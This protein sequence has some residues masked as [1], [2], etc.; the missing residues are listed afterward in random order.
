VIQHQRNLKPIVQKYGGSSLST[1]DKVRRVAQKIVDSAKGGRP[2]VVVVSAMGN[3]TSELI[4][5]AR[6]VSPSPPRRE[7]DVL[8]SSGERMSTAL[9]AMA[10]QEAGSDAISLTGP[11]S[12]ILTDN[13]HANANIVDVQPERVAQE[14]AT[15]NIVIVAGFQ[16]LSPS[17]E[18]TTIGRGGSD[19]TAVALAGALDAE[20]CDIY[21]DVPGV[22][23]ADPRIVS[24]PVHLRQIDS[25]LMREYSLHGARVLHPA[26][27]E[28]AR[29]SGV[30]IHAGS[31]FGED[32][33]TRIRCEASLA[34]TKHASE[35]PSIVGVTSRKS[36]VSL[37]S[38]MKSAALFERALD[39]L[40]GEEVLLRQRSGDS[41]DLL[42]DIEDV[43]DRERVCAR[44][45]ERLRGEATVTEELASVSIVTQPSITPELVARV[46][47]SL[48]DAGIMTSSVYRRPHSVTCAVQ[49]GDRE[50]SV[51]ALHTQLVEETLTVGA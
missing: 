17:G 42:V 32:S 8:L 4:E 49:R 24:E 18:V 28:F 46:G 43:P 29:Q 37:R 39:C 1:L 2:V 40:D 41:E 23:T 31:T 48:A 21:S 20:R 11:Q 14:L 50:A 13:L 51:R 33:F 30:A 36:R 22:Y 15:G 45:R 7:L 6:E 10:L 3:T 16:G 38:R 12:G 19:T 27:I 25:G 35:K 9:L 47:A 5:R 44:L 34:F 26:C